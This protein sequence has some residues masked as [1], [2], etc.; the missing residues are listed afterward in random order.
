[1]CDTLTMNSAHPIP[2]GMP[3]WRA[4]Q[5]SLPVGEKIELLGKFIQETRQFDVLKKLCKPSAMSW[6]SSCEIGLSR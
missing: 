6:N 5:R 3:R 2:R 1:M 4:K